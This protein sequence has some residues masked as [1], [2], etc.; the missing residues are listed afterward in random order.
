VDG[1]EH[2]VLGERAAYVAKEV[3][4]VPE[5]WRGPREEPCEERFMEVKHVFSG[6]TR[7]SQ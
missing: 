4:W 7:R 6:N 5:G 3:T 1:V 2:R